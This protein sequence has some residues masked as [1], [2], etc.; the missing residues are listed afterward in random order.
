M[1]VPALPTFSPQN[2]CRKC[3][4]LHAAVAYVPER[5]A[6]VRTCKL[7]GYTWDEAPL[8]LAARERFARRIEKHRQK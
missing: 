7:C 4:T 8:D 1:S 6:L 2:P 5:D 3:G